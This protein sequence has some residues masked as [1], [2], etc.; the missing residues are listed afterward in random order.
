MTRTWHSHGQEVQDKAEAE[1]KAL[2]GESLGKG[3]P[4]PVYTHCMHPHVR[5]SSLYTKK[6]NEFAVDE[7]LN[8]DQTLVLQSN[9]SNEDR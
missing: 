9:V 5:V 7:C 2:R 4:D 3:H 6:D 1:E 8:T